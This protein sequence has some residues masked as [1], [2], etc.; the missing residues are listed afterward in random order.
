VSGAI[1]KADISVQ[2]LTPDGAVVDVP[3]EVLERRG[4]GG[5]EPSGG[6]AGKGPLYGEILHEATLLDG[7]TV[8]RSRV[9]RPTG[10]LGLEE[11][12]PR[13]VQV[14]LEGWER[15]HSQGNITGA[16]S[17]RGIRY[18]PSEVNQQYQRLGIE[19]AVG[20]LFETKAPSTDVIL[21]TETRSHPGTL[22]LAEII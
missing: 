7:A 9:G 5:G 14:N 16:E 19:Q 21:T 1:E 6:A 8:I 20:D 13:S 22:R 4:A 18:A 2:L 12:L 17:A 10:R 15:C 3:P 11:T